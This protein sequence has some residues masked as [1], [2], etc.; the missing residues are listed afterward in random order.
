M[1]CR[2]S[3]V[4]GVYVIYIYWLFTHLLPILFNNK[5]FYF[6]SDCIFHHSCSTHK[7]SSNFGVAVYSLVVSDH[8]FGRC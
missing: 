2:V 7:D 8:W 1:L 4:L 3:C 6:I 5:A